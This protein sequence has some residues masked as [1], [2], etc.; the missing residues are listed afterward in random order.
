MG[1]A[2]LSL[3]LS[4]KFGNF[5]LKFCRL[6]QRDVR[7]NEGNGNDSGTNQSYDW[8]KSNR[9]ARGMRLSAL[10]RNLPNDNIKISNLRF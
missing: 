9:A 6:H 8:L 4:V 7:L 5:S 2:A 1:S 10:L 3:T